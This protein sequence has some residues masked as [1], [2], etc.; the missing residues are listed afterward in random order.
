MTA[1]LSELGLGQ[2]L[3]R[4]LGL[5][6]ALELGRMKGTRLV[7]TRDQ[8]TVQKRVKLKE[9]TRARTWDQGMGKR[10]ARKTEYWMG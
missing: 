5:E 8:R 3:E 6:M 7:E 2:W 10:M 9:P 1:Y 4:T